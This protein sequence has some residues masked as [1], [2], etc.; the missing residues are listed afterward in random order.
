[1]GNGNVVVAGFPITG[2]VT[3]R[4]RG[5]HSG[6][7]YEVVNHGRTKLEF[8]G[9]EFQRVES[10]GTWCYYVTVGEVQLSADD[11]AKFWLAPTV[12]THKSGFPRISYDYFAAPFAQVDWHGGITF[13]E[14]DGGLDGGQRYVKMGCDFAHLWDEGHAYDYADV[15]SECRETIRQLCELFAFKM[16]CGY[17]GTYHDKAEMVE[18]K[19]R[20]FSPAGIEQMEKDKCAS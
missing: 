19:G 15:E 5:E 11:F 20:M 4:K 18:F 17:Y 2:D 13:Y 1:M 3:L 12:T 9:S 6:L 7:S 10:G 14:K 16:R 8:F